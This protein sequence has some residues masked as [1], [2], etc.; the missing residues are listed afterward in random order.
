MDESAG[1]IEPEALEL[2]QNHAARCSGRLCTGPTGTANEAVDHPLKPCTR[3]EK[4]SFRSAVVHTFARFEFH[5]TRPVR[6]IGQSVWVCRSLLILRHE[7]HCRARQSNK[8]HDCDDHGA[9][10]SII[11]RVLLNVIPVTCRDQFMQFERCD[12]SW[13]RLGVRRPTRYQIETNH[14]GPEAAKRSNQSPWPTL[15]CKYQQVNV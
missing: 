13:Q 6:L 14:T 12:H 9:A 11:P 5:E 15:I 8:R 1:L 2:T 7:P 10:S 4:Q 3:P